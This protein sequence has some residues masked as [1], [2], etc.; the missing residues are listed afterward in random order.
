M[1]EGALGLTGGASAFCIGLDKPDSPDGAIM[2]SERS[3]AAS[4]TL[5][6]PIGDY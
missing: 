3:E 4:S 6:A 1:K 2:S 5:V